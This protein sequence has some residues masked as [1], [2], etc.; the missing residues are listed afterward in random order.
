MPLAL[1]ADLPLVWESPD[2]LRIGVTR[3]VARLAGLSPA[4]QRFLSMLTA[5]VAADRLADVTK[6]CGLSPAGR[7]ALLARVADALGPPPPTSGKRAAPP[8]RVCVAAGDG[9]VDPAWARVFAGALGATGPICSIALDPNAVVDADLLVL[10]ERYAAPRAQVG[11]WLS[12]GIPTLSIR[13]RDRSV[14]LGPVLGGNGAPCLDCCN[15]AEMGRDPEWAVVTAQVS[16]TLPPSETSSMALSLAA[17]TAG[18][19]DERSRVRAGVPNASIDDAFPAD[20]WRHPGA[21][22]EL[23]VHLGVPLYGGE[24]RRVARRLECACVTLEA[25]APAPWS[26]SGYTAAGAPMPAAARKR[27]GARRARPPAAEPESR[28]SSR[29]RVSA[30]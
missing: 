10:P 2:V 22:L 26:E 13:L 8:R 12:L 15:R 29:A 11:A 20:A 21:Q 30:T 23:P 14:L 5:G 3:P 19:L 6:R 28:S 18:L 16:G 17:H 4:E 9:L 27:E 25:L 24:H 7:A 1:F